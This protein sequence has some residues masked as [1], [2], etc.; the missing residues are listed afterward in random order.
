MKRMEKT[1]K[2]NLKKN[3]EKFLR[4]HPI[5]NFLKVEEKDYI[6]YSFVYGNHIYFAAILENDYED[7]IKIS[8]VDQDVSDEYDKL[9]HW[10]RT[11]FETDFASTLFGKNLEK[12]EVFPSTAQ[13]YIWLIVKKKD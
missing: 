7:K 2:T 8:C 3:F 5:N 13:E 4:S 1:K 9:L 11:C 12:Y 6:R 10:M